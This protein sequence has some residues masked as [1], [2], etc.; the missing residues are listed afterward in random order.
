LEIQSH[1]EK[2]WREIIPISE[3]L[4]QEENGRDDGDGVVQITVA[5]LHLLL[6]V[7]VVGG[8]VFVLKKP[9]PEV[10]LVVATLLGM[11]HHRPTRR[12]TMPLPSS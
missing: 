3:W 9:T 7:V 6:L 12:S 10:Y 4:R 5:L 8:E 2:R 1:G 11:S